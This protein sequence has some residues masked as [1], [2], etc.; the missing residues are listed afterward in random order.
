MKIRFLLLFI[1]S[2]LHLDAMEENSLDSTNDEDRGG[3]TIP[4]I[5]YFSPDSKHL[6]C[7]LADK[8]ALYE[9]STGKLIG[10]LPDSCTGDKIT[11]SPSGTYLIQNDRNTLKVWHTLERSLKYTI[12][13]ASPAYINTHAISSDAISSDESTLALLKTIYLLNEKSQEMELRNVHTGQIKKTIKPRPDH[14]AQNMA[15]SPNGKL[16]ALA[17]QYRYLEFPHGSNKD[18]QQIIDPTT[19]K[20]VAFLP[21]NQAIFSSDSSQLI[22]AKPGASLDILNTKDFSLIRTLND[23]CDGNWK[24]N[25]FGDLVYNTID[26]IRIHNERLIATSRF[27]NRTGIWDL[28]TG[29]CIRTTQADIVS[30]SGDYELELKPMQ[31]EWF[32]GQLLVLLKNPTNTDSFNLGTMFNLKKDIPYFSNDDAFLVLRKNNSLVL[33]NAKKGKRVGSFDSDPTTDLRNASIS[34]DSNYLLIPQRKGKSQ[35]WDIKKLISNFK[36]RKAAR[37]ANTKKM[38]HARSKKSFLETEDLGQ[39]D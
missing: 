2:T 14:D 3:Y 12:C 37:N 5:G 7:V 29:K 38:L 1:I 33:Y 30:N 39:D 28:S 25:D 15:F 26:D 16:L 23:C 32:Y 21:G 8:L 17:L 9:T 6:V 35:L 18:F 36:E 4:S 20:D 10:D 11:W 27:E 34:H 13:V 19:G 22:I 31:G 24:F